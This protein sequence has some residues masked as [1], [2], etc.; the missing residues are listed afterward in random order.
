MLDSWLVSLSLPI[1]ITARAEGGSATEARATAVVTTAEMPADTALFLS[2]VMTCS[3]CIENKQAPSSRLSAV[4]TT[5]G[6][7]ACMQQ[8]ECELVSNRWTKSGVCTCVHATEIVCMCVYVCVCVLVCVCVCAC[9]LCLKNCA[10]LSQAPCLAL[11]NEGE[12]FRLVSS[13]YSTIQASCQSRNTPNY[14]QTS[15]PRTGLDW[16]LATV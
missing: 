11:M 9:V 2:C 4:R 5:C 10:L 8:A 7:C 1:S 14:P 15:K 6:V 12:W 13:L 3:T 16:G